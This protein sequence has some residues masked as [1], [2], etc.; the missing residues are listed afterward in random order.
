[1]LICHVHVGIGSSALDP[2]YH[3]LTIFFQCRPP[4]AP[5]SFAQLGCALPSPVVKPGLLHRAS[6]PAAAPLP[7]ASPPAQHMPVC[8]RQQQCRPAAVGQVLPKLQSMGG[9][10]LS[11][12]WHDSAAGSGFGTDLESRAM[13]LLPPLPATTD[14]MLGWSPSAGQQATSANFAA[15][16]V[17]RQPLDRMPY[18]GFS[19]QLCDAY[20]FGSIPTPFYGS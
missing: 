14:D 2:L 9:G 5:R 15:Q 6:Y 20:G 18:G 11:G 16:P 12:P 17:V 3:V 13:P 10:G 19:Q 8:E 4:P 1:M 7:L